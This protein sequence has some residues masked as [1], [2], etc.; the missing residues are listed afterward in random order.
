M[1]IDYLS[2]IYFFLRIY[3]AIMVTL[4]TTND[5]GAHVILV[6]SHHSRSGLLQFKSIALFRKNSKVLQLYK[7]CLFYTYMWILKQKKKK[8]FTLLL[9][10][11]GQWTCFS[12]FRS[13]VVRDKFVK[14]FLL[15]FH[16]FWKVLHKHRLMFHRGSLYPISNKQ[17]IYTLWWSYDW[18]WVDLK[19]NVIYSTVTSVRQRKV[20]G[21]VI[22]M[23]YFTKL[24]CL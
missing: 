11:Q 1:N 9:G 14:H 24:C 19:D 4:A 23:L 20:R 5:R 3:L 7:K 22:Q 2:S 21:K 18:E 13:L 12:K 17:L 8:V 10:T 16:S 6:V 15:H